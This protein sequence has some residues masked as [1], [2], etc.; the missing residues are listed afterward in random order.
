MSEPRF[1]GD[2]PENEPDELET[3]KANL[4]DQA[5]R[6]AAHAQLLAASQVGLHPMAIVQAQIAALAAVVCKTELEAMRYALQVELELADLLKQ[7]DEEH[8]RQSGPQLYK[9]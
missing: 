4:K 1:L 5:K 8:K 3:V 7:A 2:A 9:P 6:N